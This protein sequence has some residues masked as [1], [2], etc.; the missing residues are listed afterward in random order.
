VT[1]SD[2]LAS[3]APTDYAIKWNGA[4]TNLI[5]KKISVNTTVSLTST[6]Y[7]VAELSGNNSQTVK[8]IGML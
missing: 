8:Y 3:G 5:A 6:E 7:Y 1:G 2:R 4:D